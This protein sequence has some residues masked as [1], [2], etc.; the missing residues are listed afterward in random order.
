MVIPRPNPTVLPLPPRKLVVMPTR[1]P[2]VPLPMLRTYRRVRAR[3]Q[4]MSIPPTIARA[5]VPS[6]RRRLRLVRDQRD[7]AAAHPTVLPQRADDM[8]GP[9]DLFP[10]LV[11]LA[12][13]HHGVLLQRGA[14]DAPRVAALRA[15]LHPNPPPVLHLLQIAP[16]GGRLPRQ[17]EPAPTFP[18]GPTSPSRILNQLRQICT[19]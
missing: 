1:L 17:G 9:S 10:Q 13:Q 15:L 8:A 11:Q 6:Q 4:T 18:A 12:Q 7:R 5:V 19:G 2:R 3:R 16:H 14:V